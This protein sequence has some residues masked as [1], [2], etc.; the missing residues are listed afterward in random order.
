MSNR[1]PSYVQLVAWAVGNGQLQK[2]GENKN[3]RKSDTLKFPPIGNI[4]GNTI[5]NTIGNT[6]SNTIGNSI[7]NSIKKYI[8]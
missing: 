1:T 2:C 6:I 8:Y 4:I 7:G 5:S 3:L